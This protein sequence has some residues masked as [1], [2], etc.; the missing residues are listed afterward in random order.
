MLEA[1]L[2]GVIIALVGGIIGRLIGSY[3]T[4]KC[5]ACDERRLACQKLIAEQLHNIEAKVDQLTKNV[6]NKLFGL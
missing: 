3:N 5:P 6:N 2:C 4:V 1:I